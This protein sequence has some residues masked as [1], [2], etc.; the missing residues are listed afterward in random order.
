MEKGSASQ[1]AVLAHAGAGLAPGQVMPLELATPIRDALESLELVVVETRADRRARYPTL[2][3][4]SDDGTADG[5][6]VAVP[7]VYGGAAHGAM[8]LVF[9]DN[10][11]FR[12][13]ERAYLSTL[14]RLGGESLARAV[15]SPPTA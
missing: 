10:R 6:L 11:V 8:L 4:F 2:G 9:A 12:D 7:L 5:A 15:A 1:P 14:G 3:R 13:D